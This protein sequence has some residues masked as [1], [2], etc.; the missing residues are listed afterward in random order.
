MDSQRYEGTDDGVFI[1]SV[2]EQDKGLYLVSAM[3]AV[4][5]KFQKRNITVDVYSESPPP[6]CLNHRARSLA[7]FDLPALVYTAARQRTSTMC[8]KSR[9]HS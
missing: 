7:S 3:V 2:Q 9:L 1:R 6:S 4:T 5:G 8:F